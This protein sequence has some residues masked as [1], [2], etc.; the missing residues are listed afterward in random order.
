MIIFLNEIKMEEKEIKIISSKEDIKKEVLAL[1]EKRR[2][3]STKLSY[4]EPLEQP[5]TIYNAKV[6][7]SAQRLLKVHRIT[8]YVKFCKCC[9][10]PQETPGV[11]VPFNF[12][13]NQTDFGL[14][15]YLYFYYIKI[16]LIISV[17]IIGLASVTTIIFS[18]G[19]SSDLNKYCVLI[20]KKEENLRNL[21][22]D[23]K[24][25]CTKFSSMITN[26]ETENSIYVNIMRVDWLISMSA[27]NIKNY[28]DIFK[29][30]A[31]DKQKQKIEDV[32]LDYSLLYFITGITVLIVNYLF[33]L[34]INLLD[35]CQNF[36]ET[37]PRDY[38]VLIHGVPKSKENNKIKVEVINIITEVS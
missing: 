14:G 18:Q 11:V 31:E 24:K 13:D 7:G 34:H 22:E 17:I 36:E 27:H 8:K 26:N 9:S 37:T 25:R 19:Y 15:I 12:I 35:E 32:T 4:I 38:T 6:H 23:F 2:K 1:K 5:G 21:D 33:I 29:Y 28:H 3:N 16:C 30:D 20:F 10:L